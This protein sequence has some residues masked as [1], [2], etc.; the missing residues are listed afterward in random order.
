MKKVVL[1]ALAAFLFTGCGVQ[2]NA[3]VAPAASVANGGTDA[4]MLESFTAHLVQKKENDGAWSLGFTA[5]SLTGKTYKD[6]S[7]LGFVDDG[8]NAGVSDVLLGKDGNLYVQAEFRV[9]DNKERTK[10]HDVTGWFKVGTYKAPAAMETG[11]AVS[12]KLDGG[13]RCKMN[14]QGINPMGETFMMF[15]VGKKSAEKSVTEPAL[16]K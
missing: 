16:L 9:A 7:L 14:W 5:K 2:P 13:S 4:R 15:Y 3:P 10:Y 6:E 12:Y 8:Y 1:A 11:K